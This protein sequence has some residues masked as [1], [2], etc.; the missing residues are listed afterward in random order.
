MISFAML[1]KDAFTSPSFFE[2]QLLLSCITLIFW[3]LFAIP[4]YLTPELFSFDQIVFVEHFSTIIG[5]AGVLF[6]IFSIINTF[7]YRLVLIPR[8][9][10]VGFSIIIGSKIIQLQTP[11]SQT[12]YG[13]QL[14]NGQLE[15]SGEARKGTKVKIR[16]PVSLKE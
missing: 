16:I 3:T 11:P 13:I 4:I 2:Y 15:I 1:T 7:T 5:A 10:I 6:F 9:A 14:L 12:I 8:L